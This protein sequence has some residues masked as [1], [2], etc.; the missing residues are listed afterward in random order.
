MS[1]L[2]RA[3]LA[4]TALPLLAGLAGCAAAPAAGTRDP[5]VIT[6]MTGG[7]ESYQIRR[8][9]DVRVNPTVT[10]TPA[11]AWTVLPDVYRGLGFE[12]D[13]QDSGVRT[14]GVSAQR[15]SRRL[16]N[17][18]ASDFFD[19]GLDPGLNRPLADQGPIT[20]SVVTQVVG[21][22]GGAEL[23]TVVSGTAR[24][25]GG[26]AGLAQCRSTGLLEALIGDMVQKAVRP[27]A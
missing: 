3:G 22:G 14:L 16:L 2:R 15:V 9:S 21:V 8:G 10:A 13:V 1:T 25:T 26:N 12:P 6:I 5:A 27:G 23:R 18:A 7:G 17:R 4:V 20:A 19:C 24:P 11:E